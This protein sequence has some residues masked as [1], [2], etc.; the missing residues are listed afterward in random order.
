MALCR[1]LPGVGEL[2]VGV[3]V[4]L[5]AAHALEE[6]QGK[7]GVEDHDKEDVAVR[8]VVA[9]PGSGDGGRGAGVRRGDGCVAGGSAVEVFR[10]VLQDLPAL[11]EKA[12]Q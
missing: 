6:R 2:L 7:E 4:L 10:P 8:V 5:L 1:R 12:G 9:L 3:G 11:G